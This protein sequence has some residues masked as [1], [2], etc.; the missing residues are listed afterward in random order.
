MGLGEFDGV[1]N[2]HLRKM[3]VEGSKILKMAE[4]VQQYENLEKKPEEE[5]PRLKVEEFVRPGGGRLIIYHSKEAKKRSKASSG[6]KGF[7]NH[8]FK[9]DLKEMDGNCPVKEDK[10]ME[11][12][13]MEDGVTPVIEEEEAGYLDDPD[14]IKFLEA[15]GI[16]PNAFDDKN[17]GKIDPYTGKPFGERLDWQEKEEVEAKLPDYIGDFK[18][19]KSEEPV[20]LPYKEDHVLK[21]ALEK[22]RNE[23]VDWSMPPDIEIIEKRSIKDPLLSYTPSIKVLSKQEALEGVS[24]IKETKQYKTKHRKKNTKKND[25]I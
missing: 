25:Q 1:L 20:V 13:M 15:Q 16:D 4:K 19:M 8:Q 21:A 17:E 10:E 7:V 14:V 24:V 6:F 23:E 2:E 3:G 22:E 9:D 11:M 5:D 18:V 12:E